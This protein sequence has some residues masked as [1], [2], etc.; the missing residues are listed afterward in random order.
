MAMPRSCVIR[1]MRSGSQLL[2]VTRSGLHDRGA[3]LAADSVD[4]RNLVTGLVP[5][6]A[7]TRGLALLPVGAICVALDLP[8]AVPQ[9]PGRR[10]VERRAILGPIDHALAGR[11]RHGRRGGLNIDRLA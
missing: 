5:A 2:G 7:W 1:V 9:G 10:L 6:R 11:P 3:E 8:F 4:D